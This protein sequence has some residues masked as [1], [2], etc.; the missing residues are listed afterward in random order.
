ML[1]LSYEYRNYIILFF[2]SFVIG[3]YVLKI[4]TEGY[5]ATAG[6]DVYELQNEA[7]RIREENVGLNQEVLQLRSLWYTD[8]KA[9][10]AGFIETA[11]KDIIF[12]Q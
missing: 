5:F 9:K 11:N 3:L 8:M 2:L 10:E 6:S 12:I 1:K 4:F 7:Q